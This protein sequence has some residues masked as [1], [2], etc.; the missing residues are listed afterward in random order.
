M[1]FNYSINSRSTILVFYNG[2]NLLIHGEATLTPEFFA[3][4]DSIKSWEGPESQIVTN[5]EKS[6][7]IEM[8]TKES[9]KNNNIPVY[10]E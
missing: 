7:I 2:K 1:N 9:Q 4:K 10:F 6:E 5:E 3:N 8:I